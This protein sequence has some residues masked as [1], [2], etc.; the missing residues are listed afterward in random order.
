M[1]WNMKAAVYAP[2]FALIGDGRLRSG[3]AYKAVD[4]VVL[5]MHAFLGLSNCWPVIRN[6]RI[7][8]LAYV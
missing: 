8:A 1:Y 7:I 2:V 6:R 5:S 3:N 4:A